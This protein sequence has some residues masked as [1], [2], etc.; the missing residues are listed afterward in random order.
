ME[1]GD[2]C[3]HILNIWMN[4]FCIYGRA[5]YQHPYI[6]YMDETILYKWKC[7]IYTFILMDETPPH[8]WKR[9][10]PTMISSETLQHTFNAVT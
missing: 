4:Q 2:I 7:D 10:I 9:R 3:I 5:R 1:E 6:E 8:P